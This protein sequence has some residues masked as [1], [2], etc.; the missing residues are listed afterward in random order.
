MRAFIS[1]ELPEEVKAEIFH[2]FEKVK[3][4]GLVSGNFVTKENLHLTLEFLGEI[5]HEDVDLLVEKLNEIKFN[6][7]IAKIGQIGAFP[8]KE[9]AKVLY[10]DLVSEKI[11]ELNR[12]IVEKLNGVMSN[13]NKEFVSHITGVRI[14]S[15]KNKNNFLDYFEGMHFNDLSFEVKGFSLMKSE[16][17]KEGPVYKEIM[18]FNF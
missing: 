9:H 17:T 7:F 4:M 11:G 8:K 6:S 10:V 5:N 15:I 13:T 2:K 3:N 16:L 12:L 14:N 18:K 1:I